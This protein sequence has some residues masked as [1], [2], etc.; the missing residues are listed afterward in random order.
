MIAIAQNHGSDGLQALGIIVLIA[1]SLLWGI[2]WIIVR[3][4]Q[5]KRRKQSPERYWL[6][7]KKIPLSMRTLAF[8]EF[9]VAFCYFL[10][11]LVMLAFPPEYLG[12]RASP[13]VMHLIVAQLIL[14]LSLVVVAN[15]T[16]HRSRARGLVGGT[17]LA[18]ASLA[19]S[20]LFVTLY[21]PH[22]LGL[23]TPVLSVTLLGLLQLKLKPL[24]DAASAKAS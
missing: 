2:G 10:G 16:I 6:V 15:G 13:W 8:C 24:F 11:S 21:G 22:N 23:W 7:N 5:R 18:I 14:S 3:L 17:A 19:N 1:I 9:G 12:D 20:A 4:V